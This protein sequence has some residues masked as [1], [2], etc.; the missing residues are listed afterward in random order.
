MARLIPEGDE[1]FWVK[2][3]V[4]GQSGAGKSALGAT[5]PRPLILLSEHQGRL[6]AQ[7]RARD[8]GREPPTI[9]EVDSLQDYRDAIH[10]LKGRRDEPFRWVDATGATVVEMDPWPE[11]VV[12]DSLSD[13]CELVV[14]AIKAEAPPK[15]GDDG[16]E[17]FS[18]RH[19]NELKLRCARLFRA[20]RDV[21][22][23]VLFLATLDERLTE[24]TD[25]VSTRT[26]GPNLPMRTLPDL[27]MQ[28]TNVAGIIERTAVRDPDNPEGDRILR[29]RVRTNGPAWMK[30]KPFRPLGDFI[31]P[32][33][34]AWVEEIRGAVSRG[35][36]V[37]ESE[38]P[39]E[40]E[41]E[42]KGRRRRR[43][44]R[45]DAAVEG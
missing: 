28:A 45:P 9:V 16:L 20:F 37:G 13:A 26:L 6:S 39:A 32:D 1:V 14:D 34:S 21:K 44:E 22:A 18:Q 36:A 7:K 38:A 40:G 23:H 4:S 10:A 24:T 42:S 41:G 19:W 35:E 3:L 15:R 25:G 30:V 12:L 17:V 27:V 2:A 29:W 11:S 5:A 43:S 31:D 33:F 8:L